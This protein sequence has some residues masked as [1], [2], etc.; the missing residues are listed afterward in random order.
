L[1]LLGLFGLTPAFAYADTSVSGNISENTTWLAAQSPYVVTSDLSV[2]NNARL[3]IEAGVTVYMNAGTR[4]EIQAG[5]LSAGGTAQNPIRVTSQRTQTGTSAPGDWG[6]LVF[7][8]GAVDSK[9]ENAIVEYGKGIAVN[10]ASPVFNGLN[11]RNNQGAAITLDL[12]AS[13]AGTSNI[14][15][16]NTR[17]AVVV[18]AGEIAGSVTWG[19]KGIPY[20]VET[21]TVS[22][23]AAPK[24][25]SLAPG[26]LQQ[27]ESST[28]A[29]TGSR[30]SGLSSARFE[31]GELTASV[32]E[33]GS[34]THVNIAISATLNAPVGP[35]TLLLTADAGE[36]RLV[37][38]INVVQQ[39]PKLESVAPSTIYTGQGA[40]DVLLSGSNLTS[41]S[42]V[43][44]NGVAV[45]S[46]YLGAG[47][48]RATVPN[49]LAAGTLSIK[50]STP[51]PINVGQVL[52]SNE[53]AIPVEQPKLKLTPAT[54][55]IVK[56]TTQ[57]LTST[58]PYP[59][60]AGGLTIDLQSS[61]PA[62]VSVPTTVSVPAGETD[63]VVAA[64]SIGLGNTDISASRSGFLGATS[65][66]SV[67][68]PP[69]LSVF[70]SYSDIGTGREVMIN[71]ISSQAV[72]SEGLTVAIA[73]SAAEVASVPSTAVIPA[74]ASNVLVPLKAVSPGA[75]IVTVQA[76]GYTA[77]TLAVNVHPLA[78]SLPASTFVLPG[79]SQD[80]LLTLSDPA[81]VGGELVTLTSSNTAVLTVPASITLP[82][83]QKSISVPLT[84]VGVGSAN[85]IAS[86]IGYQTATSVVEVDT[87]DI[88]LGTGAIFLPP[89]G[90][91]AYDVTLSRPA[92][93][94]GVVV[95]LAT[96]DSAIASVTPATIAIPAGQV[97]GGTVKANV[98]GLI[99]GSTYLTASAPKLNTRTVGVTVGN[100]SDL[101]IS[102]AS[103][104]QVYFHNDDSSYSLSVAYT[105]TNNGTTAVSDWYD[106][107]YLSQ[108][109]SLDNAD[110]LLGANDDYQ[111]TLAPGE[112]ATRAA[113]FPVIGDT[114][115]GTYMV[116]LKVDGN[117]N[118]G[119]TP[120]DNGLV[121]ET[122]ET[123]NVASLPLSL[124]RPDLVIS[125]ASIEDVMC[126]SGGAFSLRGS[127]SVTNAGVSPAVAYQFADR[128]YLSSDDVLDDADPSLGVTYYRYDSQMEGLAPGASYSTEWSFYHPQ[129]LPSGDYTLFIKT[130]AQVYDEGTTTDPGQIP[131]ADEANNIVSFPI[132]LV[133]PDLA[134]SNV[135]IGQVGSN[136]S[137]SFIIPVSY[138]VTNNSTV[139]MS[140]SWVDVAHLSTDDILDDND[141]PLEDSYCV[142]CN[143][144]H[145][146]PGAS[147]TTTVYFTGGD[148]P[149]DYILFLKTDGRSSLMELGTATDNGFMY[150]SDE[151]NNTVSL[152]VTLTDYIL[153]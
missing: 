92:P 151:T 63:V 129:E 107:A 93:I 8:S 120:T 131:E 132:K 4:F 98:K 40:V 60:P 101:I 6:P 21:G 100:L 91:S 84:S 25:D 55:T 110:R 56:G 138:T 10:A 28:I 146:L 125:D 69:S 106:V 31:N 122:D 35:A 26:F 140:A 79:A 96:S 29:L 58:L 105:V 16:G 95:N 152:P 144:E 109:G 117:K 1:A 142:Y 99:E 61:A 86:A 42:T 147:Y 9:I 57:N 143:M 12:S 7:G 128:A 123:N 44:V 38:A 48:I 134:I 85:L 52:T 88:D 136:G 119:G 121:A 20:L 148:A 50:L 103:V 68:P 76:A 49:Q 27:G 118:A 65:R 39:Q 46:T 80:M 74:G 5:S 87:I 127:Y 83:G 32:V 34:A 53:I 11:I 137:G 111:A 3:T 135:S 124:G 71:V 73:S 67:I 54:T 72:G 41:Q 139:A 15:S 22:V 59:A 141:L 90:S 75:A 130:D 104:E 70:S 89:N 47:S 116:F 17:N 108:D 51:D 97:S 36:I 149:G 30:L 126:Q 153:P 18:P 23:G 62:V 150:E 115:S 112:S 45:E 2:V 114:P 33:G 94:G 24:V 64:V 145:L 19:I 82:E 113:Y 102:N 66:V 43:L 77:S 133:R 81:P 14:A 37:D 78:L 13:P